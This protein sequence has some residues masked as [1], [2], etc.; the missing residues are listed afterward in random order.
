[1]TVDTIDTG[2][3]FRK[4]CPTIYSTLDKSIDWTKLNT[5]FKEKVKMRFDSGYKDDFVGVLFNAENGDRYGVDFLTELDKIYNKVQKAFPEIGKKTR[6]LIKGK[7]T[8]LE[9]WNF[10][11]A[12]GEILVINKLLDHPDEIQLLDIEKKTING[13]PKDL[14]VCLKTGTRILIEVLNIHY[15]DTVFDKNTFERHLISKTKDKI[16]SETNG[17]VSEEDKNVLFLPIIWRLDTDI[18]S[19]HYD[20]FEQYEKSWGKL[21]GTEYQT[22]GFHI[23]LTLNKK[24]R[25]KKFVFGQVTNILKAI[26]KNNIA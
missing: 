26:N 25:I 6:E 10:L 9:D 5:R 15:T 16:I 1:M 17:Y 13:K 21:N 2:L 3:L 11:N 7:L 12:I 19:E 14:F 24:D 22:L 8:N 23:F 18:L 4:Y 20:F